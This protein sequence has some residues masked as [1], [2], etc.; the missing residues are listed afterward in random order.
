[1]N[2]C[3]HFKGINRLLLI[4]RKK[5]KVILNT[6]KYLLANVGVGEAVKEIEKA[7]IQKVE[8]LPQLVVT[9][10]QVQVYITL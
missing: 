2:L 7:I 10:I 9:K 1:M 8:V 3:L 5:R 4:K 6:I